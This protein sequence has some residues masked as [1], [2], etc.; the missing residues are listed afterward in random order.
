MKFLRIALVCLFLVMTCPALDIQELLT[1]R[2]PVSRIQGRIVGGTEA[3]RMNVD[4]AAFNHPEVWSDARLSFQ[5]KRK[6]Q[7]KIATAWSDEDGKFALK[8]LEKGSYEI[9]FRK[10]GWNALSVIIQ[11]D[12]DGESGQLC[13]KLGIADTSDRSS[14]QPCKS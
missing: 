10:S 3:I 14:F 7:R 13:V 8:G 11:V 1:Y 4:V 2:T 5:Q 12:P 6:K 9:E